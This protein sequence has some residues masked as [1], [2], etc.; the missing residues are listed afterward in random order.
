MEALKNSVFGI[1]KVGMM[2]KD[3]KYLENQE[4]EPDIQQPNE[5]GEVSKGRDQQLEAAVKELKKGLKP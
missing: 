3:G 4:L 5:P 2:G 1:P